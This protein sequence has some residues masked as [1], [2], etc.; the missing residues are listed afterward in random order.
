MKICKKFYS[1]AK[2]II[3][4]KE[5]AIEDIIHDIYKNGVQQASP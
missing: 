4:I 5:L 3:E 1:P 2:T